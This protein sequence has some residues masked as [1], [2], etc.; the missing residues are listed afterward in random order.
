VA[1]SGGNTVCSLIEMDYSNIKQNGKRKT[2]NSDMSGHK[3]L[4]RV[5]AHYNNIA[6]FASA[7]K[8]SFT[9]VPKARGEYDE[10][11]AF[12]Q[13]CDINFSTLSRVDK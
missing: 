4:K 13:G 8:E 5:E 6:S 12:E 7:R 9:R 3:H 1:T 2:N 11:L 10:F